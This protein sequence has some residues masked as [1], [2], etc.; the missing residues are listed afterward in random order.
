[1]KHITTSSLAR[2]CVGLGL[3]LSLLASCKQEPPKLFEQTALERQDA[4]STE[5]RSVLTSAEHGWILEYY[6]QHQ[7]IYGGYVMGFKFGAQNKVQAISESPVAG[8]ATDDWATSNYHIKTDKG[9]TLSFD[10]YSLPIHTFSDPDKSYGDGEGKG[11]EGDYEFTLSRPITSPDT[12]YVRGRKTLTEMR[13]TRAKQDIKTFLTEVA[14]LKAKAYTAETMYRLHL[15]GLEG[16]IGKKPVVAYLSEKGYNTM[17]IEP[18]EEGAKKVTMPFICTPTGIRFYRPF[19]GVT[20]F[21]WDD[22][23]KTYTSAQGD[24]LVGRPDPDYQGFTKYLG[25]Y[26]M[27]CSNWNAPKEVTFEQRARNVY[28]ITGIANGLTILANYDPKNERFEITTQ[29]VLTGATTVYLAAW[30]GGGS[31]SW[32]AGFGM[33]SKPDPADPSGKKYLMTDNGVWGDKCD[34]FILWVISRGRYSGFGGL[35]D[36]RDPTFTKL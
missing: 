4:L 15:Y 24:K 29:K 2:L 32:G 5:L 23:T 16:T 7:L 26:N 27:M 20:D 18:T 35:S 9:V 8:V 12:I 1:M 13:L 14:S 21:T 28:A 25:K 33:Y 19:E 10:T 36:F 3:T 6:P 22:A 34:S 31:L 30:V 17:V 11:L